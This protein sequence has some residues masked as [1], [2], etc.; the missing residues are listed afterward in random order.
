MCNSKKCF[1][2]KDS[3]TF[4]PARR[5]CYVQLAWGPMTKYQKLESSMCS[6]FKGPFPTMKIYMK[7]A[8]PSLAHQ[9]KILLRMLV[10][11]V[12][13]QLSEIDLG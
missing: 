1:F 8:S 5:L 9:G 7:Q 11:Q 2:S 4:I 12:I 10:L 13:G 3:V 6:A